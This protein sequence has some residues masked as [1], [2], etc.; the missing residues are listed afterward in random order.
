MLTFCIVQRSATKNSNAVLT[1]RVL[2]KT[3]KTNACANT[4]FTESTLELTV[5]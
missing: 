2:G 1:E 5:N 4:K 3:T